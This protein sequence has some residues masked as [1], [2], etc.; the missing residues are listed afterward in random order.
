MEDEF[1]TLLGDPRPTYSGYWLS[2]LRGTSPPPVLLPPDL[3][4][5]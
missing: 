3:R 1:L 5:L 2:K 4:F